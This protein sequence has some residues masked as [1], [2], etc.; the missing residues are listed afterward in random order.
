M[1]VGTWNLERGGRSRSTVAL[2]LEM[3]ERLEVD[4][5]VVTEPPVELSTRRGV[6]SSPALRPGG[7]AGESWVSVFGLDLTALGEPLPYNRMAV[8]AEAARGEARLDHAGYISDVS[9]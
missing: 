1:R 3:V 4:V 7:R 6:V 9:V 5:L 2:Q 8:V